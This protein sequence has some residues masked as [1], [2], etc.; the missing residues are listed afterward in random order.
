MSCAGQVPP[1]GGPTDTEPPKIISV[2]PAPST[3]F[4]QDSRI[5]LEF[6]EYVDHQSVEGSIFVSP[7]LGPLEFDWSGTEVEISFSDSLRSNTTYV[8]SLGTDVLDV[9]NKNRMADAFSLA[10]STGGTIDPGTITGI[11]YPSSMSGQLSGISLFGYRIDTIDPDTL[12]PSKREPDYMTQTGK[13]GEFQLP[14]LALGTYRLFAV[15]DEYKNLLYDPETD[16]Y[17]AATGDIRLSA[18]DTL[19]AGVTMQLAREDTTAPR[20]VKVS[21]LNR[22]FLF[23]E[24]SEPI[25]TASFDVKNVQVNDSTGK[26]IVQV[27]SVSP[28]LPQRK[29]FLVVTQ[30]QDS[31]LAYELRIQDAKDLSGKAISQSASS[32][33]FVSSE[34][35]DTSRPAVASFSFTDSSRGIE[36]RPRLE[37][38]FTEPV[39]RGD[40]RPTVDLRDSLDRSVPVEGG[41]ANDAAITVSPADDLAGNAWYSLVVRTGQLQDW[42]GRQGRDT[43]RAL[44]FQTLDAERLSTIAGLVNDPEEVD[45]I[46]TVVVTAWPVGKK[47]AVPKSV[48]IERPGP[49]ELSQLPEG[50]YVM[51]VFR[52]R[53][54]NKRFDA[55]KLFPFQMSERFTVAP[56]TLKLRARWPL[57]NVRI[58]LK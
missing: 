18:E 41:W 44:R 23:V 13:T 51:Q 47:N 20:L 28:V 43:T 48:T 4:F 49:F 45:T 7:S 16:E 17:T 22:G 46:G 31:A 26:K 50:Q 27:L 29:E 10:F 35:P 57:E 3:L 40:W 15:R 14:H 1:S 30:E 12:D 42:R 33:R 36:L 38:R 55:G 52:D 11:V 6:D 2:Y 53:N 5:V 21:P 58:Q 9:R 32:I 34:L 56:D 24:L 39:R 19:R 25:D 8:F 54:R 37:I